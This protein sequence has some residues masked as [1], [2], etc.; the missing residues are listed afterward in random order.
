MASN[1]KILDLE[2]KINSL[3][4]QLKENVD[5]LIIQTSQLGVVTTNLSEELI[6]AKNDV[7]EIAESSSINA[8][9]LIRLIKH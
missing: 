6:T 9:L 2:K 5:G 4:I 3:E 7:S 1:Q 8:N